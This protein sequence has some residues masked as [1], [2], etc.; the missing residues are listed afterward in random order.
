MTSST[1]QLN[2]RKNDNTD[3]CINDLSNVNGVF[4]SKGIASGN[5]V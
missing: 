5:A 2:V 3:L 1:L 4:S